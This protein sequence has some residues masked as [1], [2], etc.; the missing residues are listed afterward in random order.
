MYCW[1]EARIFE[2]N[3]TDMNGTSRAK[4]FF[5]ISVFYVNIELPSKAPTDHEV[6]VALRER[7]QISTDVLPI[8]VATWISKDQGCNAIQCNW[9]MTKGKWEIEEV[10]LIVKSKAN[11]K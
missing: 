1:H 5:G 4:R 8:R 7:F 11:K 3:H 6:T 2:P 9:S 10:A